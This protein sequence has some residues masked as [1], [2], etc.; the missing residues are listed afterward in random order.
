MRVACKI[1]ECNIQGDD[2]PTI[3]PD[4]PGVCAICSRCGDEALAYGTGE[5]SI[6]RALMSLREECSRGEDNFYVAEEDG[7]ES[8]MPDPVVKPWWQK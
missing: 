5:K 2:E 7:A 1:E 8:R 3:D 6:R 4:R